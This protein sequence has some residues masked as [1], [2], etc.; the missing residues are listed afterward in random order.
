MDDSR[1]SGAAS[2]APLVNPRHFK[3][4]DWSTPLPPAEHSANQQSSLQQSQRKN[5]RCID[6]GGG[7]TQLDVSAKEGHYWASYNGTSAVGRQ[8]GHAQDGL[9]EQP[10]GASTSTIFKSP[11]LNTS[12]TAQKRFNASHPNASAEHPFERVAA[13]GKVAPAHIADLQ[14][15]PSKLKGSNRI[16]LDL[17]HNGSPTKQPQSQIRNRYDMQG[18]QPFQQNSQRL[19][20][21]LPIQVQ[22]FFKRR[23]SEDTLAF[24]PFSTSLSRPRSTGLQILLYITLAL[25]ICIAWYTVFHDTADEPEKQLP[26]KSSPAA[27]PSLQASVTPV[28]WWHRQE[29]SSNASRDKALLKRGSKATFYSHPYHTIEELRLLSSKHGSGDANSTNTQPVSLSVSVIIDCTASRRGTESVNVSGLKQFIASMELAS[30]MPSSVRVLATT[31]FKLWLDSE[32]IDLGGLHVEGVGNVNGHLGPALFAINRNLPSDNAYLL[33]LTCPRGTEDEEIDSSSLSTTQFLH[34]MKHAAGTELYSGKALTISGIAHSRNQGER[35]DNIAYYSGPSHD[36][37]ANDRTSTMRNL[38]ESRRV[39]LASQSLFIPADW[40]KTLARLEHRNL[41]AHFATDGVPMIPML[42][43]QLYLQLGIETWAIPSSPPAG[44]MDETVSQDLSNLAESA[45]RYLVDAT[46]P[47]EELGGTGASVAIFLDD[48]TV[49]LINAWSPIVCEFAAAR[50][51][52]HIVRVYSRNIEVRR[53]SDFSNCP[54]VSIEPSTAAFQDG[55]Q[56]DVCFT[57]TGSRA[58]FEAGAACVV[59]PLPEAGLHCMDWIAALPLESL[60]STS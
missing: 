6:D 20:R 60:K 44:Y 46:H 49:D 43:R 5:G 19:A 30:F 54:E 29:S 39:D 7:D 8:R 2:S 9:I 10:Q 33:A 24:D 17:V 41:D 16:R 18:I 37:K 58:D 12:Q 1:R 53:A 57:A 42:S 3:F 14:P 15:S 38:V 4:Q 28:R 45:L 31:H 48:V 55:R 11:T 26:S 52:H 25:F 59:V 27:W 21:V 22:R 40:V 36:W 35:A 50:Q 34:D 32:N 51:F 56:P 47:N 13:N 23:K